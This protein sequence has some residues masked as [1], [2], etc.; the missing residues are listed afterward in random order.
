[1]YNAFLK[2]IPSFLRRAIHQRNLH[3]DPHFLKNNN[4]TIKIADTSS[5]LSSAFSLTQ[6]SYEKANL[7]N[8]NSSRQRLTKYHLL[9]TTKV[10]VAKVGDTVIG[11]I[12]LILDSPIGLPIDSMVP[13]DLM[14]KNMKRICEVSSF[15]ID[16]KWRSRANGLFFPLTL[17]TLKYSIELMKADSLV[18]VTNE[19]AR[20]IYEDIFFFNPISLCPDRYRNVNDQNAYAQKLILKDVYHLFK[21]SYEHRRVEQNLFEM[22]E[23]IDLETCKVND[24]YEVIPHSRYHE[25]LL[26]SNS[27][28]KVI[29]GELQDYEKQVV[30]N[31]YGILNSK[32]GDN[33]YLLMRLYPRFPVSMRGWIISSPNNF[34]IDCIELSRS[35]A[36]LF[37]PDGLKLE[38]NNYDLIIEL[39]ENI[40]CE[41]S[42]E[43]VWQENRRVGV[44][45][46]SHS[47]KWNEHFTLIENQFRDGL[48]KRAV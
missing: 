15:A 2:R 48:H 21:K 39:N 26:H 17:F 47:S 38:G 46:I 10:I 31:S 6:R 41:I 44:N 14:R 36:Q 20:F 32:I 4:I 24:P 16:E 22:M 29:L 19:R 30:F 11:T 28:A 5:E 42:V 34:L 33:R 45:I 12:S 3:V 27:S 7:L 43:V 25:L 9:P 18:I 8:K 35:G 23:E 13:I 40:S 1:M 37:L